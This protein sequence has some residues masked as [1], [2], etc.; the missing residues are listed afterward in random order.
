MKVDLDAIAW[1]GLVSLS[2]GL[3]WIIFDR[4][5]DSLRT[6]FTFSFF[7]CFCLFLDDDISYD[8]HYNHSWLILSILLASL[9][10]PSLLLRLI[11]L[12]LSSTYLYIYLCLSLSHS[13]SNVATFVPMSLSVNFGNGN[14]GNVSLSTLAANICTQDKH[15]RFYFPY[16]YLFS[17]VVYLFVCDVLISLLHL[18]IYL[19]VYFLFLFLLSFL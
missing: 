13:L 1:W 10:L 15:A 11:L 14:F 2:N 3:T 6:L 19:F 8:F 7:F 5:F 12:I 9:P 4:G 17:I 16:Q 18:F